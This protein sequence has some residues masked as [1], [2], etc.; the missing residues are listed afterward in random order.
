MPRLGQSFPAE[1][2]L[3]APHTLTL[4]VHLL[5]A[6]FLSIYTVPSAP[7]GL[8]QFI[9]KTVLSRQGLLRGL[10]YQM[11]KPRHAAVKYPKS[12]SW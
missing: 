12:P 10:F 5:A 2:G 8:G 4:T 3:P 6:N 1:T 11:W 9:L 7:L